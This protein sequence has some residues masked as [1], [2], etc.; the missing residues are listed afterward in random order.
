M[1]GEDLLV[2]GSVFHRLRIYHLLPT[3]QVINL[4][5]MYRRTLYEKVVSMIFGFLFDL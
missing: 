2:A 3:V 5:C 1:R 4:K